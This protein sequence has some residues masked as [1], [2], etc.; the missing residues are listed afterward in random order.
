MSITHCGGLNKNA[1]DRLMY[2]QCLR[3][4][5]WHYLGGMGGV[6]GLVEVDVNLLEEIRHWGWALTS[7]TQVRPGL[8]FLLPMDLIVEL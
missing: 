2:L 7:K 4:R 5:K 6:C 1:P 8:L 3:I